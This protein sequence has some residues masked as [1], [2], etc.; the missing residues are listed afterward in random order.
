MNTITTNRASPLAAPYRR[1]IGKVTFEVSAFGNP[2]AT[3]TAEDLLLGMLEAKVTQE[4][5]GEEAKSA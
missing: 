3:S 2:Q 5:F 1:K 4:D